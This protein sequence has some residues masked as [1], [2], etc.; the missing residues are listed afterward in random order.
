MMKLKDKCFKTEDKEKK[1]ITVRGEREE[2]P[3]GGYGWI[4]CIA[5]AIIQFIILGI[6]NNFGILY[7]YFMKDLDADPADTAWIGSIAFGMNFLCGPIASSLCQRFGYRIVAAVG[8]LIAAL[9]LLLTSFTNSLYLIYLT[10]SVLWG[11]GSSLN[12][13]PTMLVLGQY[14]QRHLPLANGIVTAGSG[15]GTL[16]MGPFYHF[17]LSNL[18]WKIMLRILS[19]FAILMFVSA[20]LYRPL[21]A[22][23]KRAC[24]EKKERAKLFDLSVWKIKPFVFWVVSMSLLFVG[25][26][27]PFIHLP[28]HAKNLGVPGYESALLIGYLSIASTVSRVLFGLVLNHPRINRFYVLQLCFLMMSVTCTLCPLARDYTG[29]ILYAVGFGIFDGCFVLLIAITTSDTVGSN[30]L[31]QALGTLYGV[32]S[33]PMIF[34]P[35]LAAFIFQ[36]S[37]SY[38]NAF[39]V[40]GG[41]IATGTCTL[42]LI[43]FF[44]PET[45]ENVES[46]EVRKEPLL[47]E[48]TIQDSNCTAERQRNSY[49][50]DTSQFAWRRPLSCQLATGRLGDMLSV[51]CI[52]DMLERETDV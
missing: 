36:V 51:E 9:G 30:R 43:P 47:K 38:Q 18:G 13:A 10:Y 44:M 15:I 19:G 27:V 26:F 6:H 46:T 5:A 32:I 7:T 29:L 25:Y 2:C 16:A 40:A 35:P 1:E 39:F 48:K 14:F 49:I 41:A 45:R 42:S 52:L 24:T 8:G 31:P 4:I 23:Y 17:I 33:L 50:Y 34:G 21:P 3:D 28:N 11:F 12:Y 20:L 22:K 37:G